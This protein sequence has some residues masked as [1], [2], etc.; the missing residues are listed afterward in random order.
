VYHDD[1]VLKLRQL[2]VPM[3]LL[4]YYIP[5]RTSSPCSST[6]I[7]ASSGLSTPRILGHRR[8]AY[9][10]GDSIETSVHERWFG[11][12]RAVA[13][14]GL[15]EDPALVVS[16]C[17]A[18]STR[19]PGDEGGV[20][21]GAQPSA[22]VAYN[23]LI[24]VGAMQAISDAGMRV[25]ADMSVVGFDDI[26]SRGSET[27]AEHG[28]RPAEGMGAIAANCLIDIIRGREG[29][30]NKILVPTGLVV[31]DSTGP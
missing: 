18:G 7:N 16:N 12:Q 29:L 30:P 22:V 24:A 8:I 19:A 21:P 2:T 5:T 3:V 6:N 25:P 13:M 4:G 31:R 11:Y 26:N 28:P 15:D 23:D 9:L 10:S 27:L 20:G 17:R 1:F 14:F